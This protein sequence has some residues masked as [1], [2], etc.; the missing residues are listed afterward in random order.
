MS[1]YPPSV[2]RQKCLNWIVLAGC[3]RNDYRRS[4]ATT[5]KEHIWGNTIKLFKT[6]IWS[7]QLTRDTEDVSVEFGGIALVQ[8]RDI[9]SERSGWVEEKFCALRRIYQVGGKSIQKDLSPKKNRA[10]D[11]NWGVANNLATAGRVWNRAGA[12]GIISHVEVN[13]IRPSPREGRRELIQTLFRGSP[14]VNGFFLHLFPI[15]RPVELHGW[16]HL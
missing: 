5:V 14:D 12:K 9:S 11:L 3:K 4:D 13:F 15:A 8:G 7:A 6:G 2:T 16:H 1:A 10:V